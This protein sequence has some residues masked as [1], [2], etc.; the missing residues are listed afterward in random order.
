MKLG[1]KTHTQM[2]VIQT[3]EWE[4]LNTIIEFCG[5]V[6]KRLAQHVNE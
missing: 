1:K 2:K 3:Y 5:G 6:R 4:M